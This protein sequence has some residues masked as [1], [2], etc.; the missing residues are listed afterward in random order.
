MMNKDAG[1][2]V[3]VA[4]QLREAFHATCFAENRPASK[5]L[6]EFMQAFAVRHQGGQQSDMFTAPPIKKR[7]RSTKRNAI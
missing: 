6:R 2:R 1:L 5:V 4:W 3:R 7:R